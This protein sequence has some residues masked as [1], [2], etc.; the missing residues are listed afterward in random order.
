MSGA[1]R[2]SIRAAALALDDGARGDKPDTKQHV[3]AD[4]GSP[5]SPLRLRPSAAATPSSSSSSAGSA[6][7]PALCIAAAGIPRGGRRG[8]YSGELVAEGNPPRPPGHRRSGSGALICP[9][10][11]AVRE[12]EEAAAP[13][14]LRARR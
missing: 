2:I 6:K 7:S 1:D 14:A 13:G 4:L 5:V 11:A 9:A 8:S 3:F 10:G 12:A